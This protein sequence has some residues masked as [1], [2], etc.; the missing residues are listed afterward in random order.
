MKEL[1]VAALL[2]VS[3]LSDYTADSIP[4]LPS[5]FSATPQQLQETVISLKNIQQQSLNPDSTICLSVK[6]DV[7]R[8]GYERVQSLYAQSKRF[9]QESFHDN[10]VTAEIVLMYLQIV[11]YENC[12]RH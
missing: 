3:S 2:T 6:A 4:N 10:P 9:M 5:A 12:L 11:A 1:L 7:L 8:N